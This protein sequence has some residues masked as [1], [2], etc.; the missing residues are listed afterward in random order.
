MDKPHDHAHPQ[1]SIL[2]PPSP[3][4]LAGPTAVGKSEIALRL[5]EK[6][7][8]EIISVDS[9]QV[10][11]GLDLGTAKPSP[12]DRGRV[13]HHLIDVVELTE[14]FDAA[15]FARLAHE[16]VAT[17]QSRGH[18]PILCGGTGLYFKAFLE[19]LG[20]SPPADSNLRARLEATPLPDL[21][22]ELSQHDPATFE[23]IDRK[24]PRRVIRAIEV[25]RLTGKPFSQQRADWKIK[26]QKSKIKNAFGLSRNATDLRARIDARVD[27]MFRRGL[28]AETEQLL[29][30]GLAENKTALQA[31]GYRQVVEH[32]RGERSLEETVEL[33]KIRTRQFAK[34][35]MTWFRG[36]MELDWIE[37]G[38]TDA[39]DGIVDKIVDRTTADTRAPRDTKL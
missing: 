4:L 35:Q 11:R 16:A 2:H 39:A 14:P 17:I 28:V 13:A 23:T 10:Y 15:Q 37:I 24:N 26:N 1:S 30:R 36:Q 6:A 7:G 8:G 34:R 22:G 33:V 25:I 5:A 20:D 27:D 32:L 19:G 29:K 38:Q 9:M 21:L 12:A 3:I 18:V 31:L